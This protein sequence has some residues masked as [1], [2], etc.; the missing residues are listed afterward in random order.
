MQ[1]PAPLLLDYALPPKP[2]P[3]TRGQWLLLALSAP[4]AVV[5]FIPFAHGVSPLNAVRTLPE[6][7][8]LSASSIFLCG[9]SFFLIFPLL[10]WKVRL[11]LGDA[12][13][14]VEM[15]WARLGA[16][17]AG[18]PA[19]VLT[20]LCLREAPGSQSELLLAII[21]GMI[22]LQLSGW[23]ISQRQHRRGLATNVNAL[24]LGPYLTNVLLALL[25][26]SEEADAGY[27]I[28]LGVAVVP[29]CELVLLFVQTTARYARKRCPIPLA[30][31]VAGPA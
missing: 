14:A 6:F 31:G 5:P 22:A 24:L 15:R 12:P 3:A 29:V 2:R 9:F 23:W 17:A 1:S 16:L 28:T 21:G 7:F 25:A 19:A 20:L 18:V 27:F 10:G 8:S 30:D 4:L 13:G 26:F 11:L